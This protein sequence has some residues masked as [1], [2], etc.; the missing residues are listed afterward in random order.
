MGGVAIDFSAPG[1]RWS[2]DLA[3]EGLRL[4]EVA[5]AKA[6]EVA[7]AEHEAAMARLQL[8]VIKES[9]SKSFGIGAPLSSVAIVPDGSPVNMFDALVRQLLARINEGAP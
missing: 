2:G 8:A 5:K 6:I 9:I 3:V 4:A 1:G 7:T